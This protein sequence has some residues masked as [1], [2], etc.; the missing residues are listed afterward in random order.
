MSVDN[1]YSKHAILFIDD[2]EQP[3]KYFSQIFGRTFRVHLASD[4]DEGL[5]LFEEFR[6]EIGVVVSDQRMPGL[7]GS[8]LLAKIAESSPD[9]VNILS[10]AYSDLD[11][12]IDAVNHGGIYRYVT[13]PWDI[14]ELDVTLRRAMDFFQLKE[15]H[16]SLA[17]TKISGLGQMF[18][19]SRL[20]A[21]VAIPALLEIGPSAVRAFR[22]LL[23]LSLAQ[24]E[25]D[26][27]P[28][29]SELDALPMSDREELSDR[30]RLQLAQ[31]VEGVTS[32]GLPDSGE[33][34][35]LKAWLG[36][37]DGEPAGSAC[38]NALTGLLQ[39]AASG[40]D[41]GFLSGVLRCYQHG[42]ELSYSP[43]GW[44]LLPSEKPV[45]S[46]AV[47]EEVYSLFVDDSFLVALLL[48]ELH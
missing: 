31:L 4:G 46:N 41:I 37:N 43:K 42:F 22:D 27:P 32:G 48:G 17:A 2:E 1:R 38:L 11:A 14:A 29:I 26:L 45:D 13:K 18:H 21:C 16:R 19:Q 8:D 35:E 24:S 6:D 15:Q 36:R 40:E 3:Q 9:V 28:A 23:R 34:E 20:L 39:G 47:F 44:E 30:V 7:S 10:T 5:R 12:A 25:S 33:I